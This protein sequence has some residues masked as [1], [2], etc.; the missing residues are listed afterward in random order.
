[1]NDES[2]KIKALEVYC[3]Y[4]KRCMSGMR[5][6]CVDVQNLIIQASDSISPEM[7]LQSLEDEYDELRATQVTPT[8]EM[9]IQAV[10]D[11]AGRRHEGAEDPIVIK[12]FPH[13]YDAL[14]EEEQI[15]EILATGGELSE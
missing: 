9:I 3:T 11:E 12:V 14:C 7:C 8:M 6:E 5:G 13:D 4:L 15:R 10:H 1:M 2:R